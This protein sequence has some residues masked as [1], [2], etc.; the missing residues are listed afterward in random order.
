M[1]K[2][3]MDGKTYRLRIVYESLTESFSI[4][5][6]PNAGDM[7]TGRKERDILGTMFG[8]TMQVEPEPDYPED[9]DNFF[10]AIRTPVAWH[11][12]TMPD[13]QGTITYKAAVSS[14]S[15]KYRGTHM[16]KKRWTGLTVIFDSI[17]PVRPAE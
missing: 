1:Q 11:E 15:R 9:Y 16:G 13:G 4:V 14:G 5:E 17:E 7:M 12:I 8:H 3:T 10:A 2:I 6:G